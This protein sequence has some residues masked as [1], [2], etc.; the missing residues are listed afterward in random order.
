MMRFMNNVTK[1]LL[2][3]FFTRA[4]P[5]NA[6]PPLNTDDAG[7][8]L[9]PVPVCQINVYARHARN[10]DASE[11]APDCNPFGD[12]EWSAAFDSLK[13]PQARSQ[14][15]LTIQGKTI[16][17]A[18]EPNNWGWG[19]NAGLVNDIT[20]S[21]FL[22]SAYGN[23][24]YGYSPDDTL[25]FDFNVGALRDR[26]IGS[27]SHSVSATWAA[28]VEKDLGP[29]LTLVAETYGQQSIP[30][31]WQ[32]GARIPFEANINRLIS[33]AIG[34]QRGAGHDGA[35][36]QIGFTAILDRSYLRQ[37]EK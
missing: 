35:W 6:A 2:L 22:Q 7:A 16:N 18:V 36:L 5:V 12:I 32:V 21:P 29:N 20:K 37:A 1:T 28:A 17:R 19:L 31:S 15:F 3:C 13:T 34:N 26:N 14:R 30:P 33:L 23:L 24:I 8:L 11:I 4:L 25:Q 10:A 9:S 27:G